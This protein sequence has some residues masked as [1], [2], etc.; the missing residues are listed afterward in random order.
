MLE[1]L[2]KDHKDLIDGA[3]NHNKNKT[4]P[5]TKKVGFFKF[6]IH[7]YFMTLSSEID[8]GLGHTPRKIQL[9]PGF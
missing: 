2:H 1:T 7:I 3:I 9:L 8:M 4:D 6:S 5:S